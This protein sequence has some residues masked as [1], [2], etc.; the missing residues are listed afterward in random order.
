M[1]PSGP[2]S[3]IAPESTMYSTSDTGSTDIANAVL[4]TEVGMDRFRRSMATA[5]GQALGGQIA[6]ACVEMVR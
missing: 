4:S 3:R 2:T 5:A 6:R 1:Y